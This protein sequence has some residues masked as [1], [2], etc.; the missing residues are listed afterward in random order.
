MLINLRFIKGKT[1][2]VKEFQSLETCLKKPFDISMLITSRN[3]DG[4]IRLIMINSIPSAI[5]RSR[6]ISSSLHEYVP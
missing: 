4:E 6:T 3:G 5:K 2:A 1:S